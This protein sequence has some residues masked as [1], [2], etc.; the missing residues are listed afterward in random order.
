MSNNRNFSFTINNTLWD[1]DVE[2]LLIKL[3]VTI[4]LA[5]IFFGGII[6]GSPLIRNIALCSALLISFLRAIR[7]RR[8]FKL[9]IVGALALIFLCFVVVNRGRALLTGGG[10]SWLVVFSLTAV[11]GVLLK[12]DTDEWFFYIAKLVAI[13]G[14]IHALAT[15]AFLLFPGF[16][17]GWFKPHFYAGVIT[18]KDYKSGLTSHYSMNGMYLAWGLISS[19]FLSQLSTVRNNK[20]WVVFSMIIL[21]GLL[22]TTKRAHLV[23]GLA[24]C[25]VMYILFNR[26]SGSFGVLFKLCIVAVLLLLVLYFVSLYIPAISAVLDRFQGMSDDETFGG[27]SDY[28]SICFE[29]W[30]TSPLT[31]HGWGSFTQTLYQSGISDL[32]RLYLAGNLSQKA[33]NVYLQLLAEEGLLGLFIFLVLAFAGVARALFFLREKCTTE[34]QADQAGSLGVLSV[35]IQIFFLLY[36]ITGNP[37]YDLVEYSIN[38][39]LGLCC[40]AAMPLYKA[41]SCC[42]EFHFE[43]GEK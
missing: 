28:Y 2:I 3:S 12:L 22:A 38:L 1:I 36:C 42:D 8:K 17:S 4:L 7:R 25:L 24:A 15:I 23:F 26:E 10:S 16:Y 35:G 43:I 31:G 9:T 20:Q 33:H 13:F 19:F 5:S 6:K 11:L 18:A 41:A 14:L 40:V 34:Q 32:R 37:L 21:I 39:L 27:R 29:M 30:K